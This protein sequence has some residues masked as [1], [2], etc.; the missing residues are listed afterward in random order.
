MSKLDVD[1]GADQEH[2]QAPPSFTGNGN[3]FTETDA[4]VLKVWKMQ[5][6]LTSYAIQ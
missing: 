5:L 6:Q 4:T 1:P 3:A 2:L